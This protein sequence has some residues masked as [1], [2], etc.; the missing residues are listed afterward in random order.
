MQAIAFD[1]Q[2]DIG[3]AVSVSECDVKIEGKVHKMGFHP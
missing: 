2:R 1:F 3:P